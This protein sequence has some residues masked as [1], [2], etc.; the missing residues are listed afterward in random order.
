MDRRA[1]IGTL[2]G[3][4]LAAPLAAEAQQADKVVRV[5]FLDAVSPRNVPW[6]AAFERR[7]MELGYVEGK[8]LEI[9]FRTAEGRT[10]HLQDL[11]TELVG[12]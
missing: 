8:N 3:G 12:A 10:D 7:L 6:I 9:D 1:F 11:A 5:G 4:L 2:A